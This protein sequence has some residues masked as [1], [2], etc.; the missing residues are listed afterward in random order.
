MKAKGA[1]QAISIIIIAALTVIGLVLLFPLFGKTKT[2]SEDITDYQICKDGNIGV[3][4]TRVTL[5]DWVI[6]EQGV[7]HCRTE[8][9]KV[10]SGKE[11][12]TIA[13]KMALCWDEYLQGK[14]PVFVTEDNNYCAFCSVLEF[15]DKNKKLNEL[16]KYLSDTKMPG[17]ENKYM[18]YLSEIEAT[19]DKR[20]QLD[21]LEL[22]NNVFIDTSKKLAVMFVMYKDA[23]PSGIGQPRGLT[24]S[25][26]ATAGA[27]TG[28]GLG[29]Y[30]LGAA[31]L[32]VNPLAPVTC[33]ASV[34][35]IALGTG[36]GATTGY[37]IGSDRSEDWRARILVT[38][39]NKQKLEQL[40]CTQL[41]GLDYLRIQKK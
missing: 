26:G 19:G 34:G 16:S 36:A 33:I 3:V 40:K 7:K 24:V 31:A 2:V 41:E 37:L 15:E 23:Y 17:S 28:V 6:A 27:L 12:E 9:V 10:S 5:F 22:Q 39:Y 1:A 30:Y 11:Y 13:K 20:T 29:L 25:A 35:L 4:K 38:E 14:E 21:N 8:R 18:Q 32:C